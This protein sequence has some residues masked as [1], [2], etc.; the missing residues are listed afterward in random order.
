MDKMHTFLHHS[1]EISQYENIVK[2]DLNVINK[3]LTNDDE[4]GDDDGNEVRMD[5]WDDWDEINLV[6]WD[7]IGVC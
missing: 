1:F 2:R 5:D 7:K 3:K 4:D 6:S